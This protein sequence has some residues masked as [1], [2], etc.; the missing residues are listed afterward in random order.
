M[1]KE[2]K[3]SEFSTIDLGKVR[4]I[5]NWV[6]LQREEKRGVHVVFV[7]GILHDL[8]NYGEI[9]PFMN[10]I[11]SC[12]QPD[13]LDWHRN[14]FLS[15]QMVTMI[16]EKLGI[17]FSKAG[18]ATGIGVVSLLALDYFITG[19]T[20]TQATFKVLVDALASFPWRSTAIEFTR[21]F[22]KGL[23]GKEGN[24]S[25]LEKGR[26]DTLRDQAILYIGHSFGAMSLAAAYSHLNGTESNTSL[27]FLLLGSPDHDVEITP[28]A[29][30]PIYS[31]R[32]NQDIISLLKEKVTESIQTEG[33]VND[34][35]VMEEVETFEA[36]S[37]ATYQKLF[38]RD[39]S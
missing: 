3:I 30:K 20:T 32:H 6:K 2:K 16:K 15:I 8:N 27:A 5:L 18:L 35:K 9:Q 39:M 37:L 21:S 4:N 19:G 31:I 17:F 22:A 1:S 11:Q 36:H 12:F 38:Q 7:N 14:P 28:L 24:E 10:S 34:A 33:R 13:S 23:W 26:I 25:R 29:G